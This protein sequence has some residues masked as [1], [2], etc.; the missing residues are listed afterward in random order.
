MVVFPSG[1]VLTEAA[2][3]TPLT[4]ARIGYQNYADGLPA[5]NV[6]VSGETSEGPRDAP[7]RPDTYEFW[8]PPGLPG[9]YVLDLGTS[10]D[11]N[12]VGL[13]G[14]YGTAQVSA[15][16]EYSTDNENFDDFS[17]EAPPAD[18]TPLMF[19]DNLTTARWLRLTVDGVGSALPKTAVLYAGQALVMPRPIYGGHAP[20]PLSRVTETYRARSRGGQ[21][22]GRSFRSHGVVV[23]FDYANL[24][25]AWYRQYFDPFVKH[26]RGRPFFV[27]WRPETFPREVVYGETTR[28]VQPRNQGKRDLMSVGFEVSGIGHE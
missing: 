26:A 3:G 16:L 15:K 28:D 13:V 6:V 7:L 8:E 25:A 4:H 23:S 20:G 1:L 9:T 24:K 14:D 17:V 5:S 11:I 18:D 21:L 27:A 19:L 2:A 10:R 22:I 12:Y